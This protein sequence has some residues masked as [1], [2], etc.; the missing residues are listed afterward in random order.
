[1]E[2]SREPLHIYVRN[3]PTLS[4]FKHNLIHIIRPPKRSTFGIHNVESFKLLTR[5]RVEFSDLRE[6]RFRHN[7]R[8]NSRAAK[9]LR[10][11]NTSPYT[12]TDTGLLG[13]LSLTA[14]LAPLTLTLKLFVL[15]TSVICYCMVTP[16]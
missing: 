3:F 5:L 15:V 2:P 1:M 16:D 14:S 12:A 9:G 7:F 11:T 8:C 10:T 4:K 13:G 6:H